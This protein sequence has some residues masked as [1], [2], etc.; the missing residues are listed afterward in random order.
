MGQARALPE[1]N[2][3]FY[4]DLGERWYEAWDDPVALLRAEG[5]LKNP[6]VAERIAA[7][8]PGRACRV[9]DVGCG[10]GFLANALSLS[11]HR[12][13]AVD[14]SRGSLRIARGRDATGRVG[15]GSA[16]AYR[17]P[18]K[19]A[20]K[21]ADA[22]VGVA[23]SGSPTAIAAIAPGAVPGIVSAIDPGPGFDVVTALD[24]LEHVDHPGD[25]IAEAARVLRPGGLFFFHTF[26]RN[27]PAWLVVIKGLE[28][29]VRNTPDRMHVISLFIKPE[30]LAGYCGE[31]GMQVLEMTG[32]RPAVERW[33]FWKMLLT[34]RVPRDF[35]F[36][37]TRSLGLSYL[38]VAVKGRR[39][40]ASANPPPGIPKR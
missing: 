30:E 11:G 33:A 1:V 40:A 5:R 17:L 13:T 29:F 37:F 4:E 23:S 9:L 2:N 25:V 31:S 6:W 35:A 26:N 15:Y 16:D 18:F 12:V 39:P 21:A 34:R 19:T 32:M 22:G 27:F 8:F 3:A 36:R 14:L 38:G 20:D 28:W 10:G 24:F 7:R